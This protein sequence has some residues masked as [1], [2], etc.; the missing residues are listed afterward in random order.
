[1]PEKTTSRIKCH[2][3]IPPVCKPIIWRGVFDGI[4]K[5]ACTL[6]VPKGSNDAYMQADGWKDFVN[7]EE[8]DVTAIEAVAAE[9]VGNADIT[10]IYDLNGRRRDALQPGVNIVKMSD[11]TTRKVIKR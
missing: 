10:D 7:I 3:F 8:V 1:M 9:S 4:D 11:G 5:T 6:K 2:A